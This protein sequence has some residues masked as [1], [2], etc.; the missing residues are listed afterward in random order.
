MFKLSFL[1]LLLLLGCMNLSLTM[2]ALCFW[3]S[4]TLQVEHD[5]RLAVQ[6]W[7]Q[8]LLCCW[9]TRWPRFRFRHSNLSWD[10]W[11]KYVLQLH[12]RDLKGRNGKLLSVE[13]E[14]GLCLWVKEGNDSR[15]KNATAA[16]KEIA[17]FSCWIVANQIDFSW[18]DNQND[19][20]VVSFLWVPLRFRSNFTPVYFFES[21]QNNEYM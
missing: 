10:N 8:C 9:P 14:I 1:C 17:D 12:W 7:T 2:G 21:T 16:A 20:G 4:F 13:F 19:L 15:L 11:N 18:L 6:G 5:V 3:D